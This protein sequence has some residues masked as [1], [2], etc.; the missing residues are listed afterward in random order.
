MK[1]LQIPFLTLENAFLHLAV[2]AAT[3]WPVVFLTIP[4]G[5]QIPFETK[6]WIWWWWR[7]RRRWRRRWRWRHTSYLSR[8]PR[9]LSV[10]QKLLH[11]KFFTGHLEQNY[12][13]W[14]SFML[15][16][17]KLLVM[18]SNFGVWI[19]DKLLLLPNFGPCDK[20]TMCAILLWFM[21]FWRKIHFDAI[22]A[23]LCGAKNN[24][25][26]LSV[27]H[28]WQIWCMTAQH[29][30][31]KANYF[32]TLLVVCQ[33]IGGTWCLVHCAWP[34]NINSELW[35]SSKWSCL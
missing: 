27:E 14:Q 10:E 34:I 7:M 25:Q 5:H 3:I 35:V 13:T 4:P 24:Q 17:T 29:H 6:I 9:T 18:W 33:V 12:F 2:E 30:K 8:T 19:N 22:C 16:M 26:I 21:L 20:F 23:L 28:K 1:P 11:M 15:H 32:C 31:A